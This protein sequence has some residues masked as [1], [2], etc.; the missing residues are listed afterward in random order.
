[1]KF[2]TPIEPNSDSGQGDGRLTQPVIWLT[3]PTDPGPTYIPLGMSPEDFDLVR[4]SMDLWRERIVK[5][6]DKEPDN[7][8]VSATEAP[9]VTPDQSQPVAGPPL[10]EDAGYA[11][12]TEAGTHRCQVCW[13]VPIP[14]D[15]SREIY[16]CW[17]CGGTG[18]VPNDG[19]HNA[20]SSAAAS[21]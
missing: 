11:A 1:M 3:V 2:M 4:A 13:G 12:G 10:A 5:Q 19:P 6:P 17:R 15:Q 20:Q 18:R 9:P 21:E 14:P 8:P 7:A 16:Q